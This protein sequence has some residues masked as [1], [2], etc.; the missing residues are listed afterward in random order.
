[1]RKFPS[2]VLVLAALCVFACNDS[3][4]GQAPRDSQTRPSASSETPPSVT[5]SVT[6]VA[7]GGP[8]EE[9]LFVG[10]DQSL[11]LYNTLTGQQRKVVAAGTCE[12]WYELAWSGD[13]SR[14]AAICGPG[15]DTDVLVY[16]ADGTP[17]E[18]I[19]GR[20]G[21]ITWRPDGRQLLISRLQDTDNGWMLELRSYGPT[22]PAAGISDLPNIALWTPFSPDGRMLAYYRLKDAA[23]APGCTTGLIVRNVSDGSERSFGDFAPF[24]WVLDGRKLIVKADYQRAEVSFVNDPYLLD[25][26]TGA[27]TPAP[28]LRSD[29]G[30]WV[31]DDAG[32]NVVLLDTDAGLGLAVADLNSHQ[33]TRIEGS[34]ISF[35]SDHI[36][37]G[38]ILIHDR[39]VLWLDAGTAWYRVDVEGSGLARLHETDSLFGWFSPS[40]SF[41]ALGVPDDPQHTMVWAIDG[42][43]SV[44]LGP[45]G[46]G[47]A[48]R[49]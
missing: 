39:D 22:G 24:A 34:R 35:P 19:E 43:A 27:T 10:P 38:H 13:G 14:F 45:S 7:L 17:V 5:P 42:S 37:Q 9:L 21:P 46:F 44:D 31:S 16:E 8:D 23:C 41:I 30:Y 11:R 29:L 36:P 3:D 33:K 6:S 47:A 49:P 40:A 26:D 18:R 2:I 4:E 48:W 12:S 20:S 1:M 32:P 25:V 15:V 28:E